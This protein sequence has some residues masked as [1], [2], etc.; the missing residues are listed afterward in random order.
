MAGPLTG[1]RKADP[2]R[3]EAAAAPPAAVHQAARPPAEASLQQLRQSPGQHLERLHRAA[4]LNAAQRF[5][6]ARSIARA[7][8]AAIWPCLARKELASAAVTLTTTVI[9]RCSRAVF[10]SR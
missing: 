6:L 5:G 3:R 9:G 10:S 7:M 1:L 4:E 8:S 2:H